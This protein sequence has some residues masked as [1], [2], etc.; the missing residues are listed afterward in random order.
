MRLWN[1]SPESL[2]GDLVQG[3]PDDVRALL[4]HMARGYLPYLN[5][6][7]D[8]VRR[9]QSTFTVE[10][11]GVNYTQARSSHYRVW[12]L[13]ELRSRFNL[14]PQD[15]RSGLQALLTE[16]GIWEALWAQDDLPLFEGQESR[17][18]FWADHKM[19]QVNS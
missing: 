9:G 14:V 11:D 17:L 12:C 3:I 10:V 6:N 18:P 7:V 19:L 4:K 15:L 8:A 2:Q 5:A 1:S 16:V 13:S